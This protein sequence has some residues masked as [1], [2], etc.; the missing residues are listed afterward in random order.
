MSALLVSYDALQHARRSGQCVACDGGKGY[1]VI[2][3]I[4]TSCFDRTYPS[5]AAFF[6][7][8]APGGVT[9]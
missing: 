9:R 2:W 1:L 7:S 6:A 8:I 5:I 4:N 3:H